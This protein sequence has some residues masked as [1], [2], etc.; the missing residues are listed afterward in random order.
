MDPLQGVDAPSPKGVSQGK[1]RQ[2][3]ESE[4]FSGWLTRELEKANLLQVRAE[5]TVRQ[6]VRGEAGIHETMIALH[7]ADIS[8]RL[9]MQVR[10]KVLEAYKEVMRMQM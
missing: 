3:A 1:T 4:C 6:Q 2:S 10:N 5:E 7:E 9:L 8:L